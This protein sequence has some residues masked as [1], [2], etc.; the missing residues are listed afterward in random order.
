MAINRIILVIADTVRWDYL[1]F[2]GGHVKTPYLDHLASQSVV[3]DRHYA[4]SFPTVPARF[5]FLTGEAAWR[6]VGWGPLPRQ[7]FS[8]VD[9]IAARGYITLGVVDT[10]FYQAHGYYYDRGFNYF[11]DMR[12]QRLGMPEFGS[13]QV[14]PGQDGRLRPGKALQWPITGKLIPEHWLVEADHA[15]PKT[16][17]QAA[18]CVEYLAD[19]PFFAVVD[20]WDPHEPWDAPDF[21]VKKYVDGWDGRRIHPPYGNYKEAGLSQED[22]DL[23]RGLYSA[24]LEMVDRSI[25]TL[26]EHVSHLGIADSTAIVFT[27]DHGFYFG[28][29]EYLG[30][31]VKRAPAEVTWRRSPLYEELIHV[32]LMIRHPGVPSRHVRRLTSALDIAPTLLEL[33]GADTVESGALSGRSLVPFL[34]GS[35]DVAH[36][37]VISAMPL[38]NPGG[39]VAVVDDQVRTVVDWQPI[40]VTTERWSLLYSVPG[41]QAE[42]YDL[43]RDPSQSVN[44]ADEHPEVVDDCVSVLYKA[45][46]GVDAELAEPRLKSDAL[47]D[48]E[49]GE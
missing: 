31:M 13:P 8:I 11:Y 15:A 43:D 48:R 33:A 5:D 49:R 23:A 41:E 25:G 20:T 27:T 30:K 28:E 44:L 10:P 37:S 4:A 2:N 19:R 40:T 3:F 29:H 16:M 26:L 24:K 12:S 38:A 6:G 35:D 39:Q 9:E 21:L 1:G 7:T 18:N 45:L 14:Q 46:E 36:S 32:P 47:G 42:L 17:L 22:V 34:R